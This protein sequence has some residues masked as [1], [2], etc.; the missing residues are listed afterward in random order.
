V[1][2]SDTTDARTMLGPHL[3]MLRRYA[4]ALSGSAESGDACVR[5]ALEA[6]LAEPQALQSHNPPKFELFRLFHAFWDPFAQLLEATSEAAP[7]TRLGDQQLERLPGASRAALLLSVVEGFSLQ[8]IAGILGRDV[9]PLAADISQAHAAIAAGLSSRVLII[10]DEP[11]IAMHLEAIVED[12]GHHTVAT[13]TTRDEAKAAFAETKP[14]LVLADIQLADGS[15]GLDA[16][17]DILAQASV[18]VI[19]IT[20]YPERLLTGERPEPTWLVAKPFEVEAV[21]AIIGQA[22]ML[23][24]PSRP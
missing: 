1:A 24:K 16:A 2:Q 10:E 12:M 22:L 5:A 7:A 15:S 18:P 13:A 3:P 4:R 9:D 11:I 17:K 20:A 8:E 6:V 21:T 23:H 19:F 14:D